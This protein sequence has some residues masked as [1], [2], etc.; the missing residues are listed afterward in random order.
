MITACR[1]AGFFAAH[2]IW[3][4]SDSEMLIPMFAHTTF[5][6]G[7]RMDRLVMGDLAEAVAVGWRKLLAWINC[8]DFDTNAVLSSFFNGVS[9][10][11]KGA[12]IWNASLDE[13]I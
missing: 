10:H 11:E 2:A 13:S 12:A 5:D 6:G 4:V 7:R 3:C 8:E 9:E 1:L